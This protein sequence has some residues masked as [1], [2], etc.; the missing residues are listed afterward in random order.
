M[1]DTTEHTIQK[2]RRIASEDTASEQ[3]QTRLSLI[4]YDPPLELVVPVPYRE[5]IIR[6]VSKRGAHGYGKMSKCVVAR[7]DQESYKTIRAAAQLIGDT[8][9]SSLI[10]QCVLNMSQAILEDFAEGVEH[11]EFQFVGEE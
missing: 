6:D 5:I 1:T 11:G 10:R 7:F 2:A 4:H 9:V 8:T 3:S